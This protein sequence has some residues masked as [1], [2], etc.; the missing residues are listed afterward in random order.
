MSTNLSTV[1]RETWRMRGV[2][3]ET[4]NEIDGIQLE[5]DR[6]RDALFAIRD[7]HVKTGPYNQ[8]GTTCTQCLLC[9]AKISKGE[10]HEDPRFSCTQAAK[11]LAK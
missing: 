11:A 6:F 7:H 8:D 4:L 10:D 3:G 5:R 1:P 2:G 9:G